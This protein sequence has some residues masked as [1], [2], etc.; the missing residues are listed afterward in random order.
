MPASKRFTFHAKRVFLTYPKCELP[1]EQ[2]RDFLVE[3]R[4]AKHYCIGR[5]SHV[6]G[7]HH[8]HA[9]AEWEDY[10]YTR[11]ERFFDLDGHH[12]NI[13]R[14]RSTQ[15]VLK[16]VLKDDSEPLANIKP[17]TN[18]V[19]YGSILDEATNR[20]D[21][22]GRVRERYPRDFVLSYGRIQE[23]C[24]REYPTERERYVPEYTEFV[25]PDKLREWV[26]ALD[27]SNR[28]GGAPA[29]SLPWRVL[30]PL[31]PIV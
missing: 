17:T 18:G 11:D 20:D 30:Y 2:L 29:P 3:T 27:V 6:S 7:D 8:L 19:H 15:R 12:P 5:E 23:F 31:M 16:Y 22:L 26:D 10:I 25:V 13:Q 9:Y 1:R 14:V 28:S 24:E 21:F 4:G